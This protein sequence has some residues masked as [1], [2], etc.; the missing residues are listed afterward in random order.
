MGCNLRDLVEKHPIEL[1]SLAGKVVGI[2]AFLVAFQFITSMRNRGPEGDGG[3]LSDSKGRP[4]PHLIGFLER[5]TT[6][7][8]L[9]LKSVVDCHHER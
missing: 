1:K 2:D 7:I 8:E 9:G 3:P 6:M 4:T 5:T